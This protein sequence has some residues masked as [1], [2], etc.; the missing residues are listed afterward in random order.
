[1]PPLLNF[2]TRFIGSVLL[3]VLSSVHRRIQKW[4]DC[5]KVQRFRKTVHFI[6]FSRSYF[7]WFVV[8]SAQIARDLDKCYA[9]V[10]NAMERLHVSQVHLDLVA[11]SHVRRL[12]IRLQCC[13]CSSIRLI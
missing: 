5:G 7:I 13:A 11:N 6:F 4:A 2:T 1:M 12:Q 9:D 8:K 10:D 3:S